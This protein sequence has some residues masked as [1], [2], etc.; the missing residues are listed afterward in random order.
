MG[1]S[2]VAVPC[3]KKLA[4]AV[5]FALVFPAL[6]TWLYF[7]VLATPAAGDAGN[8]AMQAVYKGGKVLQ[9]TFP[10]LAVVGLERRWPRPLRPTTRGLAFGVGF[11]ALVAVTAFGLYF[12]LLQH[13]TAFAQAPAMLR[14]KLSEFKL[15]T[16]LGFLGLAAFICVPHSLLE[17]Y[18]WRWFVFGYLRQLVPLWPAI[19]LSSL[20]F[21]AHH[22]VVLGAFFPEHFWTAALPLSLGVAIGGGVWA[23][24]YDRTG[25][26]WAPWL[27]HLLIDAAIMVIGY[28]MLFR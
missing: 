18:Y 6:M 7:V 22:V 14:G 8:A 11:A 3:R 20:G 25:S 28:V 17:E 4:A 2:T 5:V 16:P 26:I 12:G 19:V 15:A 9:F 21:M 23:W 13:S 27:S 1:V 24:L 10:L